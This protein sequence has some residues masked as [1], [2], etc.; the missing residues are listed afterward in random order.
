MTPPP[1]SATTWH[2]GPFA[3]WLTLDGISAARCIDIARAVEALGYGSIWIPESPTSKEVFTQAGLLL[4][5]TTT[6]TVG[7]GIANV[8]ARDATATA[9]AGHTLADAYPGRFIL[10]LG[11][12]HATRVADRGHAYGRPLTFMR[13]YLAAMTNAGPFLPAV[14]TPAPVVLA[15]L[16][17]KMQELARDATTGIHTFLVSPQHTAAAR[18][19]LGPSPLLIPQ[20]AFVV[21]EDDQAGRA[22]AQAYL[23][24]RLALPNYVN[25]LKAMGYPDH[26]LAGVGSDRLLDD[27]VAIGP[28]SAVAARMRAHLDAGASQVAAHPLNASDGGI[29]QLTLLAPSLLASA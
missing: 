8:W 1:Q 15:A 21:T 22:S 20:Q 4:S 23:R 7:T 10:G 27:L 28:A 5:V 2:T 6:L 18:E 25:H 29:D 3:A 19:R 12:S 24:S 14:S 16:Q 11:T 17:P 26:E 9:A 13:D